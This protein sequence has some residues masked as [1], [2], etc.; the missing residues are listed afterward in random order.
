MAFQFGFAD[1]DETENGDGK[2]RQPSSTDAG[3]YSRPVREH[4]LEEL[5]G[6]KYERF[7]GSSFLYPGQ[8]A[9]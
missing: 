3:H 6:T 4:G 8:E 2:F 5:V 9:N 1:N 7:H